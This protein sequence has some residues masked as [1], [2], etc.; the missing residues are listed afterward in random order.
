MSVL[1]K[2]MKMP[3]SCK[4][5][6]WVEEYGGDYD[7]CYACLLTG[8][9]PLENA[10]DGRDTD[11]P[12]VEVKAPHGRLGDLDALR[13]KM[14]HEAFETDSDMQRWESGCWIRYKLFERTEE[15]APTVLE[16][17]G[18]DDG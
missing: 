14:Y 2:G 4:N 7:W 5:C 10:E 6:Q 11:C 3:E 17:E 13:A 15:A 18:K 8:K 1:I 12:L 9:M 16:A